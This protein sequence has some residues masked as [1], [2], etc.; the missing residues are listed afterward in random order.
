MSSPNGALEQPIDA[1]FQEVDAVLLSL[2]ANHT[3]MHPQLSGFIP[4]INAD[5]DAQEM[6]IVKT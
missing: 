3:A 4:M 6:M 2:D 1:L 5:Q